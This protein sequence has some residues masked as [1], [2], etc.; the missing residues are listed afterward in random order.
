LSLKEPC[1]I[2]NDCVSVCPTQTFLHTAK[3]VRVLY[4]VYAQK[5]AGKKEEE[6]NVKQKQK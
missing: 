4:E 1:S 6:N 5:K 3:E 2:F